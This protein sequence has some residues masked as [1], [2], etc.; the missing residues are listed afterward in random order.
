MRPV[1]V[2]VPF[3]IVLGQ[4]STV[5]RVVFTW[6]IPLIYY[7]EDVYI[8]SLLGIRIVLVKRLKKGGVFK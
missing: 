3:V 7:F 6:Y 1:A 4:R 8:R 2:F 5:D